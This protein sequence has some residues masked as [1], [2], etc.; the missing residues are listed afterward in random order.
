MDSSSGAGVDYLL[1]GDAF[2]RNVYSL[3][4]YGNFTGKKGDQVANAYAQVLPLTDLEAAL[5]DFRRSR[6]DALSQ[7]PPEATVEQIRQLIE[8]EPTDENT[9]SNTSIARSTVTVTPSASALQATATTS[10]SFTTSYLLSS[11]VSSTP[12]SGAPSAGAVVENA[13]AGSDDDASDNTDTLSNIFGPV[14]IGLLS[15]NLL[16]GIVLC[17]IGLSVCVRKGASSGVSRRTAPTYAPV[18]V[19]EERSAVRGRGGLDESY[20][21]EPR[22]DD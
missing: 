19:K 3:F 8:A 12:S 17:G 6:S 22:Y 20:R 21:D 5:A 14:V 2:L 15:G 13:L 9:D 18:R 7:S 16:V 11:S 10:N 1:L 4:D